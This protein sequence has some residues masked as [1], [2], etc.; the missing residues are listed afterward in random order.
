MNKILTLYICN[1]KQNSNLILL[2]FLSLIL[3]LLRVKITHDFY[4][5]FLLWNLALAYLPY[6][7]SSKIKSTMPG[8]Y[9]FYVLLIGWLLFIPN[10][11]YL[12]TDFVH[13]HYSNSLQYLFDAMILTCFTVAGFYAGIVS[14]LQIHA[15]LEIKYSQKTCNYLIIILC[16]LISFG[17]YLGRIL[18]FNSWDI[19]S[20]P[21]A[22]F[23]NILKSLLH[24]EAYLFTIVMGTLIL[25]I[26]AFIYV[27]LN[28]KTIRKSW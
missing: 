4:L 15:L 20:K 24:I 3:I 22:L 14:M 7:L 16:Y 10:S 28:K 25:L 23:W 2:A 8:T 1:K 18:R 11:F 6:M 27:I 21:V 19:L 26:Y 5:L 13:L 9:T 17:I 12:L